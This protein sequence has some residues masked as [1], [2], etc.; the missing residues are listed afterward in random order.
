MAYIGT[1]YAIAAT[2]PLTI[3][4]YFIQ[5]WY[6]FNLDHYYNSSFN[7]WVAIVVV[8]S[9]AG[10]LTLAIFRFRG[11]GKPLLAS[12]FENYKWVPM[13]F[14]FMGGISMHVS[15][16]ILSHLFSIDMRY[17]H[18]H[19]YFLPFAHTNSF[20]LSFLFPLPSLPFS[21]TNILCF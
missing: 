5:G 3:L 21:S 13:F 2:W 15:Q 11:E 14:I 19:F 1:Y 12:L 7:L 18:S 16:A 4:N 9:A 20:T 10:N 6:I 8:F 17:V